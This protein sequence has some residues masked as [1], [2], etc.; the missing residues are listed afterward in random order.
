[1]TNQTSIIPSQKTTFIYGLWDPRNYQLRYIGKADNPLDRLKNH[2][3]E[4]KH[5]NVKT[6]KSNWIR[7]LLSE[8]LEPYIEILEEV[9]I[10]NWQEAE[11]A[12]IEECK[13]FGL[14]LTNKTNGGDGTTGLIL[15]D[16]TKEK[17][18]Q[19]AIGRPRTDEERRKLSESKKGK[20]TWVKGKHLTEEHKKR[21]GLANSGKKPSQEAISKRLEKMKGYHHSE[22]VRQRM[23][24]IL[25][26][27]YQKGTR[28]S[29]KGIP[30]SEE[31]K[32]KISEGN[33]GRIVSEETRKKISDANKG[34]KYSEEI[35]EA[36]RIRGRKI[37][38][39]KKANKNEPKNS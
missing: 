25:K 38:E 39:Q 28:K 20:S 12:W 19:K 23:S 30:H 34:R 13:K 33:K 4:A 21:I 17:M 6:Y 1:M 16:E 8:G 36:M 37:W 10:D 11:I 15:S 2:I 9:L 27:A 18:R 3:E 32:K 5:S 31:H 24:N 35:I 22:E 7:Q 14:K 26:E 29:I